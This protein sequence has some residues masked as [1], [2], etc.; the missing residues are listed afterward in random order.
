MRAVQHR[1]GRTRVE[2]VVV[3]A[4]LG[5]V[6]TGQLVRVERRRADHRE[7]RAGAGV[8]RDDGTAGF[9]GPQAVVR[10]LLRVRVQGEL[11]A[12]ALGLHAGEQVDDPADEEAVVG[13]GQHRVGLLLDAGRAVDQ[14]VEAGGR[15]V[16]RA[17]G[18]LAQVLQPVVGLDAARDLLAADDDR[19]ALPRVLLG[20]QPGVVA[21]VV[22]VLGAHHLQVV[23][24]DQQQAEEHQDGHRETAQWGIHSRTTW[25]LASAIDGAGGG[26][27]RRA[28]SL[29][30]SSSAIS[31]QF[32]TSDE[33]P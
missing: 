11:D 4:H 5:R 15:G 26:A 32:A 17:V 22:Q 25:V 13:A 6:V 29:I 28:A 21:V 7:D 1:P 33:P 10:R 9:P 12:A 30:R 2:P 24:V 3:L 18:V 14:R 8:D 27:G 23:D 31:A 16:Q 20:D 19:P